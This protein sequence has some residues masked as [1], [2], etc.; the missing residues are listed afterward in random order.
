MSIR[1]RLR[2]IFIVTGLP[3]GGAELALY[4]LIKVLP[5]TVEPRVIC[6]REMGHVG[7]EIEKLGVEVDCLGI[8]PKIPSPFALFWL[9]R[10][11]KKLQPDIVQT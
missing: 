5:S 6:L 10:M 2:I 9:T 1:R 7:M 4:R 8:N 11:L 3:V